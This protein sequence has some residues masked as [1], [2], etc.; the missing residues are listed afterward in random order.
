MTPRDTSFIIGHPMLSAFRRG[1]FAKLMLVVL[2]IGLFAIVI[3]GFGTGG[4]G[5]GGVGGAG[6]GNVARVGGQE[7]TSAE[8]SD[9]LNRQLDRARQQQPEL[10]MGRF[11]SSG[12]L[13]EVVRQLITSTALLV[14]G[15]ENGFAASA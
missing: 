4:S 8:V 2:G 6:S 15:R 5:L 7:I 14:F 1:I 9:T 12:A 3:T 11:L 10:D 13:E